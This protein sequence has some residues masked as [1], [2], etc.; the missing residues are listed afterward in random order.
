L[1]EFIFLNDEYKEN[2]FLI[3]SVNM[4]KFL[5]LLI[6][7][8]LISNTFAAAVPQ[9]QLVEG[10]DYTILTAP[11]QKTAEPKGK[12]NVKEFFSYTCIHCKDV[13]PLVEQVIV[14]N[15]NVD[16]NKIQIVWG[17]KPDPEIA[18]LAKISAT[19]QSLGL[20]QLN[21]PV[22]NAVSA[23]Q[24]LSDQK[25][26]KTFLSQNGLKPAEVDK[27]I[28]IYNSFS[29]SSKVGEY[30]N[31]MAGYNITGTPTFV[32]ADKYVASAALPPR[33]IEVVQALIAKARQES[34]VKK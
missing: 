14:P 34:L 8:L 23:G 19:I 31:Q 13:E 11:V 9:I 16:L 5:S 15:K 4:L 2:L 18:S 26:L 30:K 20:Q 1:R 28:A 21:I 27:F 17:D 29:I 32:V 33:L 6:G 24:K 25:V 7:G 22:F 12:V 10:K 3:G